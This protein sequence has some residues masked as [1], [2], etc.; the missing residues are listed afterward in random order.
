MSR[1]RQSSGLPVLG[2]SPKHWTVAEAAALLGPPVLTEN[3][4]R[5]L[6][7]LCSIPPAGKR[8][9]GPRTRG[10]YPLA[11][12]AID[13]IEAYDAVFRLSERNTR[14]T[15]AEL[16]GAGQE[17]DADMADIGKKV[18]RYTVPAPVPVPD[19]IPFP[20]DVPAAV[21]DDVPVPA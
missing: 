19:V 6:I 13:L 7:R 20:G 3:Q 21:P 10:R 14:D 9:A 4:V 1:G 17:R 18:R 16:P 15:V 8:R 5:H 12:K 11:Y 2:E